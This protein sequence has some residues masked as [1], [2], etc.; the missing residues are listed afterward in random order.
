MQNPDRKTL[1]TLILIWVAWFAVLF[2]FQWLVTTRLSVNRP[3]H[4]VSWS[5]AETLPSSNAGKI[6]LL[7]P[8]LNRQV[9]WDSEYYVGIA[10][11]GYDDPAAGV[12]T[13][14]ATNLPVI[15]NY[16]FFPLYPVLMK[17]VMLPLGA[18]GMN[19]IATASLA[20]VIVSLLGTLAGMIALWELTRHHF[21]EESAFRSILFLLIFPTGFFLAQ[22]YTEGLFV[23]LAFWCL[24]FL[25]RKHWLWASLLAFFAAWTRAHGA[26][27][28]VPLAFAWIQGFDRS[29]NVVR[30]IDLS[31]ILQGL[32]VL[33]PLFAYLAW[34]TSLLGSGWAELQEFYFGRGLLSV[35][36]SLSS[37]AQ[38]FFYSRYQSEGEGLIYFG[39]EV[40]TV[41]LA[42]IA[43]FW[44]LRRDPQVALFSLAIVGLS[45]LSGSAQSMARYMLVAPA[46]YLFLAYLGRNW[47]FDR[48]WTLASLL[49]MGMSVMLFSFDMWVG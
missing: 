27:L 33:L 6:Y 39:I 13:N 16:S 4:A 46:N 30:Q 38:V 42:A 49:I 5:A 1:R 7:E 10:V 21:D 41:V 11:A 3:D 8:F 15:K 35:E 44:L 47:A 19:A 28:V 14:P 37:W 40:V 32:A 9:A 31:K 29:K 23:G 17:A 24:V 2:A 18:L 12:V 36:Q 34:R 20:G 45:V 26:A 25:K 43:G 22:V 48:A